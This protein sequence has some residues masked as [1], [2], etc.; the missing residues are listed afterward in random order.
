[1][2]DYLVIVSTAYASATSRVAHLDLAFL[3][4]FIT[5]PIGQTN[6]VG[7]NITFSVQADGTRPLTYQWQLNGTNLPNNLIVT[8]AG[9]GTTTSGGQYNGD[10]GMATNA[11][12]TSPG[13][14]FVD[15]SGGV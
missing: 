7:S 12:V 1:M 9:N 11:G 14:L 10:G 2:G 8:V 15:K 4:S 3:P 6:F 13:S 5:Q